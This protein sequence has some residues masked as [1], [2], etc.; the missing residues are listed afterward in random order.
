MRPNGEDHHG[1]GEDGR[2]LKKGDQGFWSQGERVQELDSD[3]TDT[4]G[5]GL[6]SGNRRFISDPLQFTGTELTRGGR[7][8]GGYAY[9]ASDDDEE[10]GSTEVDS[11]E[12]EDVAARELEDELVEAALA[13]IRKAQAK[14]KQD[15]KLNKK[16]LAALERRRKR[17]EAEA[18]KAERGAKRKQKPERIAVPLSQ[19]DP[20]AME[21]PRRRSGMSASEDSSALVSAR[22]RPG[23]PVGYFA[24]PNASRSQHRSSTSS[25]QQVASRSS[26]GRGT[27]DPFK[28]QTSGSRV[29][30]GH[31]VAGPRRNMSGS[32]DPSRRAASSARSIPRAQSSEESGDS[33]TSDETGN[34]VHISRNRTPPEEIIV[35]EGSPSPE[36]GPRTRSK[37]SSS[38]QSPVKR[39]SASG[40][41]GKKRKGK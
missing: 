26:S 8:R 7:S 22:S 3:D 32:S 24:P 14:G 34:G 39:K 17:L 12:D 2:R 13:R 5:V 18:E 20:S 4:Q 29:P 41:S 23:P 27:P 30:S 16:E 28:Y 35:L 9:H 15:V 31:N 6:A 21:A 25:L 19:F 11:E 33:T 1:A 37:T 10:D 40:T 36:T 38:K